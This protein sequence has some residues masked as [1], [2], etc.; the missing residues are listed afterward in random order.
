MD[1]LLNSVL[2]SVKLK[3]AAK[4]AAQVEE[5]VHTINEK[6]LQFA[7]QPIAKAHFARN[8]CHSEALDYGS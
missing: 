5:L 1:S 8:C 4:H 3:A 2:G 6:E 7:V